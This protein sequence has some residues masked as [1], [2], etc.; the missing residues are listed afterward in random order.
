MTEGRARCISLQHPGT[1][2]QLGRRHRTG[3]HEEVHVEEL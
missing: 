1:K 3:R 2:Q